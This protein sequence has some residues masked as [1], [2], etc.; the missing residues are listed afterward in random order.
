MMK[1]LE[2]VLWST[3][4]FN[5]MNGWLKMPEL[6]LSW[7]ANTWSGLTPKDKLVEIFRKSVFV[8]K[9][10]MLYFIKDSLN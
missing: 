4:N 10:R 5:V 7:K 3:E 6:G 8:L 9:K 2:I 1:H